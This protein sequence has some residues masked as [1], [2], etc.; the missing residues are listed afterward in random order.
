[1]SETEKENEYLKKYDD[2]PALGKSDPESGIDGDISVIDGKTSGVSKTLE[3]GL[4][5]K[6]GSGKIFKN[7]EEKM[8]AA[9]RQEVMNVVLDTEVE[10]IRIQGHAAIKEAKAFWDGKS[11]EISQR[12]NAYITSSLNDI[13]KDRNANL[14]QTIAEMVSVT[15]DSIKRAIQN[16]DLLE[17]M[18]E[19]T[20]QAAMA[21]L[22]KSM[23]RIREENDK[24]R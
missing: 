7:Q 2:K 12:I 22:D 21:E 24:R 19:R 8:V 6:D 23:A 9:K 3:K 4:W 1:M 20:I 18:R 10:R 15:N 17:S 13:E 14:N 11:E 16:P 5:T